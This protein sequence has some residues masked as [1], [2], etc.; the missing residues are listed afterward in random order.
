MKAVIQIVN[1]ANLT[2]D[3]KLISEIGYG[4]V[5]YLGVKKGD[6]KEN[7]D[8]FI[9]KIT[10]LRIFEDDQGKTNLSIKDVNGEILLVSQFTLLANTSHGNRPDFLD[11]ELPK[12]ANELYEYV[13][14]GLVSNGIPVKTGVFGAD[15]TITQQNKGPFTIVMEK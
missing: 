4:Y 9:K 12:E 6:T 15:M 5:I 14:E 7:A 1:N 11:A 13:K 2:V 8:Y 10:N 3:N